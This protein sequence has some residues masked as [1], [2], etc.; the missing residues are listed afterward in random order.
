MPRSP[1]LVLD[2]S[3]STIIHTL[4]QHST[5]C[6]EEDSTE[7]SNLPLALQSVLLLPLLPQPQQ[8]HPRNQQHNPL[9]P[10]HQ[11]LPRHRRHQLKHRALQ[12][13]PQMPR[14]APPVLHSLLSHVVRSSSS[15]ILSITQ[16]LVRLPRL[17][18]RAEGAEAEGCCAAPACG[19]GVERDVR[20]SDGLRAAR[21]DR[22]QQTGRGE[23]GG[24]ST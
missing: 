15:R 20:D 19:C 16:R 13:H 10:P 1:A 17:R 7:A 24:V 3:S 12:R 6:P 18:T 8:L 23:D 4:K 14:R 2:L 21:L 22:A 11:Q 5:T 9:Q